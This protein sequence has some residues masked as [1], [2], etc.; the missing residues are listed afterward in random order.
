[1]HVETSVTVNRTVVDDAALRA[2]LVEEA[3]RRLID[4]GLATAEQLT[5]E[6]SI[7][8]SP[9]LADGEEVPRWVHVTFGWERH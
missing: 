9:Q 8:A 1:M 3:R 7:T 5:D 6:P 2:R 4:L